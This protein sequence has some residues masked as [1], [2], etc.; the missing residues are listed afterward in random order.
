M[1]TH[2]FKLL[3]LTLSKHMSGLFRSVLGFLWLRSNQGKKREGAKALC[4]L[5]KTKGSVMIVP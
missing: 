5:G 1:G 4:I 2:D 3:V